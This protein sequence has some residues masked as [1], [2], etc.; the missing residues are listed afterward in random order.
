MTRSIQLVA[1]AIF[2]VAAIPHAAAQTSQAAEPERLLQEAETKAKAGEYALAIELYKHADQLQPRAAISC[3]VGLAYVR[4][5]AWAQA[6]LAFDACQRRVNDADPAPAW[7]AKA[8]RELETKIE[9]A[10]VPVVQFR[11]H[12]D[13]RAVQLSISGWPA[14]ESFAP[15]RLHLPPGHYWVDA[16][17]ADGR[18][19]R[20][21]FDVTEANVT[22]EI[23]LTQSTQRRGG[24]SRGTGASSATRPAGADATDSS[25]V[26]HAPGSSSDR[27][28]PR[29]AV[30]YALIGGGGLAVAV[31]AVAHILA[32]RDRAAMETS[33]TAWD[34][35]RTAFGRE[36]IVAIGGY[37][38]GAALV[39]AGTYWLFRSS[40]SE[41]SVTVAPIVSGLSDRHVGF[42]LE[43]SQ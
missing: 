37:A 16:V 28:K 43:W 6:E 12:S 1:G 5:A 35:H 19:V 14:G 15:R 39:A 29:G 25:L 41:R 20:T 42:A 18:S 30:G 13:D 2:V 27:N 40:A 32:A 22:V 21:E 11:V 26:R 36:R 38:V 23:D 3:F 31:G 34:A 17:G 4:S 33:A 8:Q 10:R 7:F 24:E 9:V